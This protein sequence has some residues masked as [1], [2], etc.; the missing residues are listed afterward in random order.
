MVEESDAVHDAVGGQLQTALAVAGQFG[1]RLARLRT[2]FAY[3]NQAQS[4]QV[5]R[6][7]E[8][9][10]E[11][12]RFAARASFAS[13]QEGAW[14][15]SATPKQIADV[16]ETAIVWRD[17]DEAATEAIEKIRSEIQE[18]YGVDVTDAWLDPI[19]LGDALDDAEIAVAHER[20][21]AIEAGE[22]LTATQILMADFVERE[23]LRSD[24]E[25]MLERDPDRAFDA[26]WDTPER[27]EATL[28][29][30]KASDIDPQVVQAVMLA[31]ADQA[32]HPREAVAGPVATTG[33]AR[34]PTAVAT[35]VQ[36][37]PG[38]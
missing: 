11:A 20:I 18:R 29:R 37:H 36:E 31:D 27:R 12:E 10:F 38:R 17:H 21:R 26:G 6:E 15:D 13:V 14:W 35:R 8:A 9:R 1:E 23:N 5:A 24:A 28:Q 25:Q 32:R 7:L 3:K 16:Y 34:Q 2:E 4:S 22:E 30:L 33:K 19:L